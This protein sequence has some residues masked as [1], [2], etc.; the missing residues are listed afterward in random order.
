MGII[1]FEP[2]TAGTEYFYA[3]DSPI[4]EAFG[5]TGLKAGIL[6]E[7]KLVAPNEVTLIDYQPQLESQNGNDFE[8]GKLFVV[9]DST[10]TATIRLRT[11]ARVLVR[12][13][14]GASVTTWRSNKFIDIFPAI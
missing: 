1:T 2:K 5:I 9:F 6:V 12:I 4:L 7:A 8:T 13:T 3:G 14:D 10:D 11:K